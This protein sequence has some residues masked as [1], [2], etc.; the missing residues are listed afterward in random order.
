M[1]NR[2][3]IAGAGTYGSYI[4]NAISEKFPSVEIVIIEVG[5]EEIKNEAE[6]GFKSE[7][8]NNTYNAAKYGRY[9]GL[10]GTSS[11]WGG[12][13]LFFSENDCQNDVSMDYI[14]LLNIKHWKNVLSRFFD[15]IPDL[16]EH[17]IDNIFYIKKGIW[18]NFKKRNLF[19]YFNIDKKKVEIIKNARVININ[20][21]NGLVKSILIQ[22]K[23]KVVQQVNAD[24]FFLCCGAIESMRIL[25][26]SNIIDLEDETNGF[27]DHVST[28][29]FRI[30]SRPLIAGHDFSY[31]F[32]NKSLITKRIVGEFNGVSFYIQPVFNENFYFFQF[33]KEI[34]F[35]RKFSFKNLFSTFSQFFYLFPFAYNF[36]IKKKL[37]VY[38]SW[39]LNIDAELSNTTCSII[40]SKNIDAY[41]TQGVSINYSIPDQTYFLI[42]YAKKCI[43]DLLEK[44]NIMVEVLT[45]NT[46]VLKLEDTYHPF[47][48][49][50]KN[51]LFLDRFNPLTN[52]YVCHTGI[53]DRAGGLNPTATLFCLIEELIEKNLKIR[54]SG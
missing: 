3:C 27:C 48:L 41:D 1:I 13:L 9:F 54:S 31:E 4:A 39:E 47:M 36:L 26:I 34:I 16:T 53:L 45:N 5:N 50:K 18:L 35:K 46:T 8:N 2:V 51:S 20:N 10:G 17:K 37:Y 24:V 40:R 15:N 19:K 23:E 30:K 12:Q 33:L 21:I 28:R 6:I 44:E 38:D 14:K 7:L 29:S 52:L 49:Y 11:K 25:D 43:K 32:I 42:N 22:S